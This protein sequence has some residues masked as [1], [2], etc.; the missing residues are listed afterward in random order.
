MLLSGQTLS[1][2]MGQPLRLRLCWAAPVGLIGLELSYGVSLPGCKC[3]VY[4]IFL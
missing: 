2:E 1:G 4:M 3:F